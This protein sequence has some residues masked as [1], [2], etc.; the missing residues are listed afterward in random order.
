MNNNFQYR[1]QMKVGKFKF[2]KLRISLFLSMKY[3]HLIIYLFNNKNKIIYTFI[4]LCVLCSLSDSDINQVTMKNL[5]KYLQT[6]GCLV[7][8]LVFDGINLSN[9]DY[10]SCLTP[11]TK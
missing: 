5:S 9:I 1:G 6:E 2:I 4:L 8:E 3:Y 10:L 11:D 7:N